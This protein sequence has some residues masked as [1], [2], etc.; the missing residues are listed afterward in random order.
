[1]LPD[2]KP[3]HESTVFKTLWNWHK[4]IHT[5]VAELRIQKLVF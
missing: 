2:F 4:N 1:M 5:T 3:H